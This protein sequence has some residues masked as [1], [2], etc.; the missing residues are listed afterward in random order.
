MYIC[1]YIYIYIER[2]RY[3]HKNTQL[4]CSTNT[5]SHIC[6]CSRCSRPEASWRATVRG[7]GAKTTRTRASLSMLYMGYTG[8]CCYVYTHTKWMDSSSTHMYT[9]HCL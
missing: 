2:E 8:F 4:M 5:T 7:F 3:A 6:R 9:M 1:V